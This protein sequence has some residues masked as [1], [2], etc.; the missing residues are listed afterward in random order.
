MRFFEFLLL[1]ADLAAFV[2]LVVPRINKR[3]WANFIPGAAL[4]VAIVQIV[5]EGGRWQMFPAYALA[6][7]LSAVSL[8]RL[9]LSARGKARK[10][11]GVSFTAVLGIILG[12][13]V[14]AVAVT[15]PAVLP[16]FNFRKPTGPYAVG[17]LTY[18]WTDSSR[19]E[20]F[21]SDPNDRRE[22]MAQVWYPARADAEGEQAKYIQNAGTWAANTGRVYNLPPFLLSHLKYV[23]T[24]AIVGAPVADDASSYPVLLY[25]SGTNGFKASSMFQIEELVSR[26]YIVVGLDQ[27]GAAASVTFPDDRTIKGLSKEAIDPFVEQAVWPATPVPTLN[28]VELPEGI[29]PYLGQDASFA[30]YQLAE[31]NQQDP[32]DILTGRLDLDRAGVFGVS[33]GGMTASEACAKDERLKAC[34]IM[35]VYIPQKIVQ[36]G[37][38]QPTMF[39]TRPASTIEREGW[40]E[41]DISGTLDTMRAVYEKLPGDGY[42]VEIPDMFHLNFTDAPKWFLPASLFG[43]AGPIS[44]QRGFDIINEYSTAFFDKELKNQ[45]SSLLEG[46]P[47]KYESDVIFSFR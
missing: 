33:L 22:L 35:D 9:V 10:K 13:I 47:G 25:L 45:Q 12:V 19:P 39:I 17:T 37:L 38:R 23:T 42:Y 34:L 40:T 43:L 16:V 11:R 14:F 6:I 2:C 26:G 21:T 44:A 5:V 36:S 3:C 15:L 32:N 24:N 4:V 20:I 30:L 1:V 28:G 41:R 8:Y 29:T 18:H 27:P 46:A 7:A 31:I